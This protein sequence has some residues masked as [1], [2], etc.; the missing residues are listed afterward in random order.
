MAEPDPQSG[1]DPPQAHRDSPSLIRAVGYI[2]QEQRPEETGRGGLHMESCKTTQGE[3]GEAILS[4]KQSKAKWSIVS[5]Y[6][7]LQMHHVTL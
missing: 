6:N 4:N 7:L 1:A 3:C 2:V 5:S